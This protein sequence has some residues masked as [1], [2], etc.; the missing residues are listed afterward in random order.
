MVRPNKVGELQAPGCNSGT[1]KTGKPGNGAKRGPPRPPLGAPTGG[2][3]AA[4][5]ESP[6]AAAMARAVSAE[7][8]EVYGVDERTVR[9]WVQR[10]GFFRCFDTL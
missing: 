8:L 1:G 5:P 3:P 7:E 9:R 10:A 4:R 2:R 6:P